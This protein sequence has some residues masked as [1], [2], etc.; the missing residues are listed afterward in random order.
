VQ[1]GLLTQESKSPLHAA[2]VR[3]QASTVTWMLAQKGVDVDA[4]DDEKVREQ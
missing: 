2:A 3:F 1:A 4:I